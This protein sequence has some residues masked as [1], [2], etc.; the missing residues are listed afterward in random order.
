MPLCSSFFFSTLYFLIDLHFVFFYLE[1]HIDVILL[2]NYAIWIL[3]SHQIY[4]HIY[5]QVNIENLC[6]NFISLI[7]F[8]II[9]L[10]LEM[11][12]F[13]FVAF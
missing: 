3:I 5:R 6:D 9:F 4:L 10:R 7:V 13:L 1:Q 11:F 2:V 12:F 8:E